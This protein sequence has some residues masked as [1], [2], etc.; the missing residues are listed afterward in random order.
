MNSE[1]LF[2]E[3]QVTETPDIPTVTRNDLLARR[4]D[5]QIDALR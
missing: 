4:E 5:V 1:Q 3:D 2:A